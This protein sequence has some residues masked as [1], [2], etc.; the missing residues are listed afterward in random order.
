[1]SMFVANTESG[2]ACPTIATSASATA[3]ETS[4]ISIGIT[5]ARTEPKTI[6]RTISAA[7]SPNLSSPFLRSSP[8]SVEKSASSVSSPVIAASSPPRPL[9]ASTASTTSSIESSASGPSAASIAVASR[10]AETSR[11]EPVS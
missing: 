11:S 4:A 7:G 8:A 5:P 1:M 9:V 10:S 3:M 2:K 6:R